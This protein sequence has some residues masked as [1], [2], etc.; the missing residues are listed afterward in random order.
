MRVRRAMLY[1]PGDEWNKINKAVTLNVDSICMDLEDGTAIDRKASALVT[2]CKALDELDFGRSERLVRV[3]PTQ[4][5]TVNQE[6]EAVLPHKPDGIVLPKL[7]S[8]QQLDEA[9]QQISQFEQQNSLETGTIRLLAVVESAL[10]IL[11]LREIAMHPRLDAIIFGAEDFTANIGAKRTSNGWEVLYARSAVVTAATAYEKQPID[12][13]S[14]NFRD[15]VTLRI[16]AMAGASLGFTGKQIIHPN[17][18]ATVQDAFSPS[19]DEIAEAS[20]LVAAFRQHEAA[21]AGAFEYLGKM[22]D[23]P[24]LKQAQKVLDRAKAAGKLVEP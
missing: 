3:N 4:P 9:S 12:M 23:M 7:E 21:G 16:E 11:N 2:V 19:P 13:V 1:V 20:A 5:G 8:P 15:P 18:V 14:I 17:Q 6:I 24:I 10:G 22:V